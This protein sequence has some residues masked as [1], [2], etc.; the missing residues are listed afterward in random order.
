[1]SKTHNILGK[2]GNQ[3]KLVPGNDYKVEF[4]GKIKTATFLALGRSGVH[5]EL[6]SYCFQFNR[7]VKTSW[8]RA[9]YT[10]VS[11]EDTERIVEQVV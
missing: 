9:M 1:M 3:I 6:E 7:A 2:H 10:F 4:E 5:E 8:G 11:K